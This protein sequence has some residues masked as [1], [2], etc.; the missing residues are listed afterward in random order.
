MSSGARGP[1]E[2]TGRRLG[3]LEF[4]RRV[5][6]SATAEVFEARVVDRLDRVDGG[7]G[8]ARDGAELAR[9][10][11]VAVKRLLP[12]TLEHPARV[13]GFVREIRF[14]LALRHPHVV[15]TLGGLSHDLG[16]VILWS[17]E[18]GSNTAPPPGEPLLV[19][20][21]LANARSAAG[22]DQAAPPEVVAAVG[23]GAAAALAAVHAMG[24][25]HAD[26]SAS[27]L[28]L[29]PDGRVTLVDFGSAREVAVPPPE[30]ADARWGK[31]RY[32]SPEQRAG[33]ALGPQSDLYSLG[34]LLRRLASA[35]G[36]GSEPANRELPSGFPED[37][38]AL[39]DPC[40]C[41]DAAAR[42]ED[43]T[44]LA[45]A[46]TQWLAARTDATPRAVIAAWLA[47]R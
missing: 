8:G 24:A 28:L 18:V 34:V 15:W 1:E 29:T 12:H 40:L 33:R 26:V 42:P 19:M 30:V 6:L 27:N 47:G 31:T 44:P 25:V 36:R 5:A 2:G 38:A 46:L 35:P 39:L 22:G 3:P 13:A 9:G 4:V 17:P 7:I 14:G 11:V 21:Y 45:Q 23:S 32:A 10:Q 16:R 20:E 41:E 37:L 43:A